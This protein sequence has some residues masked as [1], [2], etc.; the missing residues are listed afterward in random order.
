MDNII[1]KMDVR[2]YI[3]SGI[4]EEYCL[5]LLLEHQCEEVRRLAALFPEIQKE[6]EITEAALFAYLDTPPRP[7]LK[8][9]ILGALQNWKK[10]FN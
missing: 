3:E 5:G 1:F 7:A 8:G 4:V 6:I 2:T 9:Q 10:L